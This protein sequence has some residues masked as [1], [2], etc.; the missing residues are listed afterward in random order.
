VRPERR[1]AP[2]VSREVTEEEAALVRGF[3]ERGWNE[4]DEAAVSR[5][6]KAGAEC[7]RD[8]RRFRRAAPDLHIELTSIER[9]EKAV[10]ARWLARGTHLGPLEKLEPTG[11]AFEVAGTTRFRIVKGAI[12]AVFAEWDMADLGSQLGRAA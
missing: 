2:A 8:L 12:V 1:A 9:G 6:E 3:Y 11:R 4:G 5:P 10:V 7:A